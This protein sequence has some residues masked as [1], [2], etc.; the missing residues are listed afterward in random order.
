VDIKH[1]L[2]SGSTDVSSSDILRCLIHCVILVPFDRL[3]TYAPPQLP[4][5]SPDTGEADKA[6][7][8]KVLMKF[9]TGLDPTNK[10]NACVG[11]NGVPDGEGVFNVGDTV[12]V[13]KIWAD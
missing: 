7:P 11:C 4:N 8:F 1:A 10:L 3:L 13:K 9:R 12:F 2:E 6:V 5:V